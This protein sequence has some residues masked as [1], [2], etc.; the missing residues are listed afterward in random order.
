METQN[1]KSKCRLFNNQIFYIGSSV[2]F[3]LF[4]SFYWAT[5]ST[6]HVL[7]F[8]TLILLLFGSNLTSVFRV[9]CICLSYGTPVM[10]RI[11]DILNS[12]NYSLIYISRGPHRWCRDGFFFSE[13]VAG[14]DGVGHH[15]TPILINKKITEI[16]DQRNWREIFLWWKNHGC[17]LLVSHLVV[18]SE[19]KITYEPPS[20]H[21]K[22]T[23]TSKSSGP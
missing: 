8:S 4:S 22:T 23:E 1:V 21:L 10:F 11:N 17:F 2:F 20:G 13:R 9:S 5:C 16:H 15:K 3:Q 19:T 12:V 18:I 14:D 6:L 7:L